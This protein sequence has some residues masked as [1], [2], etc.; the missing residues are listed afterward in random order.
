[1]VYGDPQEVCKIENLEDY[2]P[3]KAGDAQL[4]DDWRIA[5]AWH[6]T[7]HRTDG[8]GI[9]FDHDEIID[10][11]KRILRELIRRGSKVITFNPKA[12]KKW[13]R[14][15]WDEITKEIE[16]PKDMLKEAFGSLVEVIAQNNFDKA[17][18]FI[19]VPNFINLIG[20]QVYGKENP[21]DQDILIRAKYDPETSELRLPAQNLFL[22]IERML[23][24]QHWVFE[25][26]GPN[27]DHVPLFDLVLCK[28][29]SFHVERMNEEEFRKRYYISEAIEKEKIKPMKRF[30]PMKARA[31]YGVG[32]FTDPGKAWDLWA[33]GIV[34]KSGYVITE[35]KY[36]GLRF[37]LHRLGEDVAILTEDMKRDRVKI[38]PQIKDELLGLKADNFILDCEIVWWKENA[39]IPRHDMM[40]IIVGK[41]PLGEEDIR[42]NIFDILYLDDKDL[43]DLPYEE[44]LRYLDRLLP[45]DLK[46]LKKVERLIS[47]NKTDF[48]KA[49]D[50]ASEYPGSEGSM[51][52]DPA[53]PY[54]ITG[55]RTAAWIKIK[56]L[57]EIHAKIIG[58]YL[59]PG[60]WKHKG[61]KEPDEPVIGDRAYELF[62]RLQRDESTYIFRVAILRDGKLEPIMS[63]RK[64]APSDKVLR[65]VVDGKKDPFTGKMVEVGR[66]L[67]GEWR[68]T[69]DPKVW[70]MARGFPAVDPSGYAYGNTYAIRF[71]PPAKMG[72]IITVN[73]AVLRKFKVDEVERFSWIFPSVR[74]IALA[75][76]KPDTAEDLERMIKIWER[77]QVRKVTESV[78]DLKE[79]WEKWASL[80]DY[81]WSC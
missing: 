38:L 17:Q 16:V 48:I 49:H 37:T 62:K 59:K 78:I 61:L 72:D 44:R 4:R 19:F 56:L 75:R 9:K 67:R 45:R 27:W 52:K 35:V 13:S 74:E 50:K 5:L 39:P 8:K 79:I 34:D 7:W 53:A 28:K 73:P 80:V 23:G 60:H 54:D 22:K 21:E 55:K 66:G 1:M 29:D 64:L 40:A 6:A 70:E 51:V 57:M 68:G 46:Y 30:I 42:A 47:R 76:R 36:D 43:A 65:W 20:S 18:D 26:T 10:V 69:E 15:A 33:K 11:L 25:P 63:D 31:G 2:D 32:L 81:E 58:M 14:E 12:M 71:D 3:K 77:R 41:E 24:E